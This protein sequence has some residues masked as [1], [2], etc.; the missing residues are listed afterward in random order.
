MTLQ[1]R[2]KHTCNVNACQSGTETVMWK[3]E[4]SVIH[5]C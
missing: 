2:N 3:T 4:I 1:K 5:F